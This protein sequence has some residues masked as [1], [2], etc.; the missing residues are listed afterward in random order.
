MRHSLYPVILD[1]C[2]ISGTTQR[3]ADAPGDCR[4]VSTKMEPLH[5]G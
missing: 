3:F 1:A 5:S 2:V 4:A